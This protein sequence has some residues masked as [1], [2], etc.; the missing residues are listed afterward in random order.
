MVPTGF[1][2]AEEGACEMRPD[3]WSIKVPPWGGGGG[4]RWGLLDVARQR[5]SRKTVPPQPL[6]QQ[7]AALR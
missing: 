7:E 6:T 4:E 2:K 1:S 5:E 3:S